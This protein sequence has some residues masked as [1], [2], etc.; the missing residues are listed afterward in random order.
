MHSLAVSL[1]ETGGDRDL[2]GLYELSRGLQVGVFCL[3]VVSAVFQFY[4]FVVEG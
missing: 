1:E 3:G 2:P 4:M